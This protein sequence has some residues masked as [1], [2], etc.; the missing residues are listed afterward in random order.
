[1]K[2]MNSLSDLHQC[3]YSYTMGPSVLKLLMSPFKNAFQSKHFRCRLNVLTLFS[4]MDS[5]GLPKNKVLHKCH[6]RVSIQ[7]HQTLQSLAK[8]HQYQ[9]MRAILFRHG[10][11]IM[12]S[13]SA[14]I[15]NVMFAHVEI[16]LGIN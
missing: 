7:I 13:E 6:C 16:Q 12:G 5:I 4:S 9:K 1:M 15:G 3:I 8:G 2:Q 11:G 14:I 10:Y